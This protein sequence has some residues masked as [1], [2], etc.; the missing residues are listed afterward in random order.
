M[1]ALTVRRALVSVLIRSECHVPRPSHLVVVQLTRVL[2][3]LVEA[4]RQR[5]AGLWS[6]EMERGRFAGTRQLMKCLG[7]GL[8][9]QGTLF[10]FFFFLFSFFLK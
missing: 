9:S 1:T 8:S 6:L 2:R 4:G 5:P 3:T 10:F 7:S